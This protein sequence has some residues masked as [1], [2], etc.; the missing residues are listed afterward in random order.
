MYPLAIITKLE[1]DRAYALLS[2]QE[3]ACGNK[4][5]HESMV[6]A[7]KISYLMEQRNG[8]LVEPYHC[9]WCGYYH[10]GHSVFSELA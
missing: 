4:I 3:N 5:R 10:V 1:H 2:G 7:T 9:P 8:E 6:K